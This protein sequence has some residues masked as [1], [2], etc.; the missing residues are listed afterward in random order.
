L[1]KDLIITDDQEW[2]FSS[3]NIDVD[4]IKQLA[5]DYVGKHVRIFRDTGS[6][7]LQGTVQS[8]HVIGLRI[9]FRYADEVK[10]ALQEPTIFRQSC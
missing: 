2:F 9:I 6:L 5:Q 3:T 8:V 10:G 7:E 1:N 4:N